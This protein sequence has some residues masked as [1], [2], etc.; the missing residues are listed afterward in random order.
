[1]TNNVLGDISN[2][3]VEM[4]E[5]KD[6]E[7]ICGDII[8][9]I[10]ITMLS[11]GK[12]VDD[13]V[14]FF[15]Q[16]DADLVLETFNNLNLNEDV[17]HSQYIEELAY[18]AEKFGLKALAGGVKTLWK[19]PARKV[20]KGA[21]QQLTRGQRAREIQRT[22]KTPLL[23]PA[24]GTAGAVRTGTTA[25]QTAT[26]AAAGAGAAAKPGLLGRVKNFFTG[27]GKGGK[28][29]KGGLLKNVAAGAIGF[30][31]GSMMNGGGTT[32][33]EPPGDGGGG[34]APVPSAPTPAAPEPKPVIAD[35]S[36]VFPNGVPDY[37][38]IFKGKPAE[39]SAAAAPT[40]TE[41][42]KEEKK[43]QT[44]SVQL[45][46]RAPSQLGDKTP[47]S[48]AATEK[49]SLKARRILSGQSVYNRDPAARATYDPRYDRK[50][51]M[52]AYDIVLEYLF[53]E[54]HVESVEEAHYVMMQMDA[55]Y[56]QSIVEQ[57]TP[58]GI[59]TAGV[60]DDQRRGSTRDKDLK[61]T[62]DT[63]RKMRPYPNG[64]PGVKG[65]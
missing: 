57:L 44:I 5:N 50:V 64:F 17:T 37:S 8:A 42:E 32:T 45:P 54:G 26:Q 43:P 58:L 20:T 29:G 10:S 30:A 56:I 63:L 16:G 12:S 35:Y 1:M 53:S 19:G 13:I 34:G 4:Q 28:G 46:D 52:E 33:K 61:D 47:Y 27:L 38:G 6:V 48:K 18:I 39:P 36:K 62:A 15:E 25:T 23:P 31:A 7:R 59:K 41:K 11:E 2:L 55:E 40:E 49:M 3:Y 22:L 51:K 60:V 24:G 14:E 9:E 21:A 65:V